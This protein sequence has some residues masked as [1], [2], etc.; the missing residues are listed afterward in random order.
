M[1][2]LTGTH[3]FIIDADSSSEGVTYADKTGKNATVEVTVDAGEV[4]ATIVE[5]G[6]KFVT[7]QHSNDCG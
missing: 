1:A 3:T 4:T 5:R 6:T 7:G 2:V